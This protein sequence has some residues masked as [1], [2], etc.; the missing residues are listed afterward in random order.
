MDSLRALVVTPDFPPA[1]GG[2]QLLAH[3]LVT[4]MT[5]ITCRILT[6]QAAGAASWDGRQGL[7][8]R[9]IPNRVDRRLG[10][11]RMNMAGI[12]EARRFRPHVIILVHIVAAPVAAVL[13]KTR[14]I[15]IVTYMHACEVPARP[16][17]AGLAARK[18]DRIVAVSRY[19]ADLAISAG[20]APERIRVIP[21][22]VDWRESR[23]LDR[24]ATPTVLTVARLE[25]RYKGHDVMTRAIPLVRSQVPGAEWVVVGDGS[26]RRDIERLAA[27]HGIQ[28]A[29][30]FTGAVDDEERDRWL[31]T[32]HVFAMPSRLP[33]DGGAGEGFGIV[34]LEA[35]VHG[36]PV[37]AGRAGGALDAVVD[38]TTGLLVDPTDHVQVA[39]AITR[40]LID[41]DAAERMGSA[42]SRHARDYAWP[43]IAGR[44]EDV[45]AEVVRRA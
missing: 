23:P 36:L 44:V 3:R 12:A 41:R 26:L 19:T 35:G 9:R 42:G 39:D 13:A 38:G 5:S 8:I 6:L 18:S 37:V 45:V 30:R 43:E 28:D 1:P 17:M 16:K 10:L 11:L 27:A 21:P 24:R 32:A 14:D 22:G 34:Y 29:I 2:I 4:H 20:A 7:D 33:A 40:L 25:D 31:D 15:P